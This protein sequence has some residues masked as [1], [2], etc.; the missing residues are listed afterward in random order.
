M[1]EIVFYVAQDGND[2]RSGRQPAPDERG[3][4]GPFA[5]LHRAQQAVRKALHGR[6]GRGCPIRVVVGAGVYRLPRPLVFHPADSGAAD[7]PVVYMAAPGVRPVISGGRR[8]TGWRRHGK[9]LWAADLPEVRSGKNHFRQLFVNGIRR[10]RA[11]LPDQD[12]Y[13]PVSAAIHPRDVKAQRNRYGFYC[14]PAD[15]KR[16]GDLAD[17]EIVVLHR[18]EISRSRVAASDPATGAIRLKTPARWPIGGHRRFFV[19]NLR[20]GLNGPGKW[21]LDRRAGRLYY[22]PLPGENPRDAEVVAPALSRLV[23]LAGRPAAG[24]FVEYLQFRGLSFQHADWDLTGRGYPGLQAAF[25]VPGAIAAAGARHCRIENCEV[26]HVGN[27]AVEFGRGCQA[28]QIAGNHLHDLGGGGVKIGESLL[29]GR[30]GEEAGRNQVVDNHVHAG[31]RVYLGAVGIWVGRGHDNLIAHNEIHDLYYTGISIGW[32]WEFS[33]NRTSGNIIEFNHVHHVMNRTLSDGGGIYTLGIAPG[34]VIRNNLIH[35]IYG[36]SDS[37]GIYLDGATCGVVVENNIVH[38][39]LGPGFRA[40]VFT[41]GNIIQN[42]IFALAKT[43]QL[44]FDTDRPNVFMRNIV[45]WKEGRLFTRDQW[46]SYD[47]IFANNLYW[48]AGRQRAL[49]GRW[50]FEAWQKRSWTKM[51]NREAASG[52][53]PCH[54]LDRHSRVADPGFVN[55]ARGNFALKPGSP[56]FALGF[57]RIDLSAVGPRSVPDGVE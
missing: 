51:P 14:N 34:T 3:T 49:F 24:E 57:R 46:D 12:I 35:D 17:A 56:A 16:W 40:Q 9:N 52:F 23:C 27:Y 13:Y 53:D 48:R 20:A 42:N 4:D 39:T 32:D 43:A 28:N 33:A 31:G 7:A 30:A 55:P 1:Q 21:Y 38:H 2:R 10:C 8:I 15:L 22:W 19:D 29:R 50:T 5:G 25:D 36:Y 18:W 54:T 37:R 44:G 47:T 11:R 41:T 6:P 45:Y 26:A